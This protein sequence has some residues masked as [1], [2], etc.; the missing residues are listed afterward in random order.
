MKILLPVDGS[1]DSLAAVRHALALR[2]QGLAASFVLVNI[3]PSASLYEMVVAHDAE[4][5]AR[6]RSEAGADLLAPAEALLHAAGAEFESEVAGGDPQTMLP[7]LI[8]NY[9]CDAV[10]MGARGVADTVSSGHGRVAHAALAH[11]P[12]PVTLVREAPA[13]DAA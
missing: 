10:V 13:D 9:G 2:E 1:A 3:Q 8:E 4:V 5:I 7:E 6:V 11:S 12:V